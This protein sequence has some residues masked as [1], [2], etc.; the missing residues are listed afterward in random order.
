M[1]FAEQIALVS[2]LPA[3]ACQHT[4]G[5]SGPSLSASQLL[6]LRTC[7]AAREVPLPSAHSGSTLVGKLEAELLKC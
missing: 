7:R 2:T 5:L 6:T 4:S 1:R 3:A